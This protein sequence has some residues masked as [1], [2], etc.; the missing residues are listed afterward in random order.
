MKRLAGIALAILLAGCQSWRA[1]EPPALALAPAALER[2]VA[3][4]QKISGGNALQQDVM[5]A[6][7]EVQQDTLAMAGTTPDGQLLFQ[8]QLHDE[9]ITAGTA[10]WAPAAIK[11][12]RILSD[13]QLSFWPADSIRAAL[14]DGWQLDD[15]ADGL[16]RSLRYRDTTVVSIRYGA[17]D[18]WSQP[19]QF[20]HHRWHYQLTI[21]TLSMDPL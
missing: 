11:P 15:A 6:H 17:S 21:E 19:V 2:H 3:I 5:L 10:R 12:Q 9:T 14:P 4:V 16:A 7:I 1:P 18:R 8:L 13:F 20:T